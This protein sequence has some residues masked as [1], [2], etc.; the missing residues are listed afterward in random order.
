MA[1]HSFCWSYYSEEPSY[2]RSPI[3]FYLFSSERLFWST[4]PFSLTADITTHYSSPS[5]DSGFPW[6]P[7]Y[8]LNTDVRF[9]PELTATMN[10]TGLHPHFQTGSLNLSCQANF[11]ELPMF[12]LFWLMY[13]FFQILTTWSSPQ[14]AIM[15]FITPILLHQATSRTQSSWAA[16]SPPNYAIIS[17]WFVLWFSC[18]IFT[19]PSMP[20]VTNRFDTSE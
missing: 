3:L 12:E 13:S 10:P 4:S 8:C 18:H 14:V 20:P 9:S 16:L 19:L 2:W 5:G 11:Q 17:N 15:S 6:Y 1:I 7:T